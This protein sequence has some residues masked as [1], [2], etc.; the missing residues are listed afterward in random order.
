DVLFLGR[1]GDDHL[2]GARLDMRRGGGAGGEPPGGLDHDLHA[3]VA[4]R[5]QF[6][7]PFGEYLYRLIA[8]GD[9]IAGDRHRL[10]QGAEHRVVLEQMR[11]RLDVAEVVRGHDLD[12]AVTPGGV[13]GPPETPAD[14][15]EP[16]DTNSNGHSTSLRS[17]RRS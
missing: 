2:L 15:P 1:G 16:V 6:R 17:D 3:E 13:Q 5:E 14:P 9:G 7:F 12:T 11:H 4:P 10:R 8:D